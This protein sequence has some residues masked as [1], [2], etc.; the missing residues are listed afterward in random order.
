MARHRP[1]E[2]NRPGILPELLSILFPVRC[3]HCGAPGNWLC[4]ACAPRLSAI[5][6]NHC[7][8]C[9]RPLPRA[10]TGCNEC[11]GRELRFRAAAAAFRFEGPARSLVHSLK[12]S[13][14]R[15]LA[16]YM[17]AASAP[18]LAAWLSGQPG[19][20]GPGTP[21]LTGAQGGV[22]LTY[23]PMHSSKLVSR[24]YNQAAIYARALARKLGVPL[25]DLLSRHHPTTP[26]NRLDFGQRRDNLYGSITLARRASPPAGAAVLVDDVYTTGATAAECAR[27]LSEGLGVQV[28]IWTFART[29]RRHPV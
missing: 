14:Q 11:R 10:A 5:G 23:V 12:Y 6:S 19:T 8:R 24:G 26:Q 1:T 20:A 15:R 27:V 9:G 22:T 29:V 7:R 17:A 25:G 4:Q 3:V 2:I 16:G 28:Y 13:G 21:G 18:A